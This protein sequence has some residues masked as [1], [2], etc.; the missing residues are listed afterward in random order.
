[1]YPFIAQCNAENNHLAS[2]VPLRGLLGGVN[3]TFHYEFDG[4]M[5]PRGEHPP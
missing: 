5:I 2:F 4:S 1:M 3:A